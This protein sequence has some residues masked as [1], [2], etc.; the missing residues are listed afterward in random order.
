MRA[1][2]LQTHARDDLYARL[3]MVAVAVESVSVLVRV[4]MTLLGSRQVGWL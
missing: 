1:L 4:R 3:K 2:T